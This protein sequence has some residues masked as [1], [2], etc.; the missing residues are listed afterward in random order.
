MSAWEDL[1]WFAG[2]MF[3]DLEYLDLELI[4][5]NCGPRSWGSHLSGERVRKSLSTL[6]EDEAR[7]VKRK[8]RK[9]HRKL[10]RDHLKRAEGMNTRSGLRKSHPAI[11]A[12]RKSKREK[13][14]SREQSYIEDSFGL[15]GR[16]PSL[17]QARFRRL[18][19]FKHLKARAK[20]DNK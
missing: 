20:K 8:F 13:L 2:N 17:S 10:K 3:I 5:P 18:E 4:P 16:D 6:N 15:K 19:V 14:A 12:P 11:N 7:I 1:E 9:L